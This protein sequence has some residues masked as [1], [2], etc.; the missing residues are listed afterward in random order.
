MNR[1]TKFLFLLGVIGFLAVSCNKSTQTPN[2]PPV[3]TNPSPV[4]VPPPA[5]VYKTTSGKQPQFVVMA[6][7]G[8]YS[9]DMWK[10]TLD[11]AAQMAQQNHPVHFTYF[12]SGVYFLNFR[13]AVRYQPPEKPAGTSGIGFGLSNNDIEQRIAYVNRAIA[14]GHEIG[15][16]LNGH[17][18]GSSWSTADWQQEFS[19]FNN[20]IFNAATNNDVSSND[21]YRFQI[22]LKPSDIIGLRAPDLG[23]NKNLWPVLKEYH[24]EY[25]TS[26]TSKP[27]D[28]PKKLDNGIWEFPLANIRYADTSSRLLSM[29]YNFYFKQS[30]AVDVAK[31]GDEKWAK[32]YQETYT[33][34]YNYFQDNYTGNRAPVFIGSHFSEWND[35]VYWEAMRDFG[36]K[37]CAEPEVYCVDFRE[38]QQYLDEQAQ[39]KN[40]P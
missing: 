7:D 33:S 1:Y 21:A 12:L 15:S 31:K 13:K 40:N 36:A 4:P 3:S 26:L 22:N 29:D 32:F 6:F 10:N 27:T 24:F 18:D 30:G 28:W 5:P 9:L 16:H 25:D 34:Y 11:F 20:L 38:L 23:T 39:P 14:E 35:G 17:F 37:V 8:S 19:Q 2:P